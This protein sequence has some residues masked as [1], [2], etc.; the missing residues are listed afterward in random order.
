MSIYRTNVPR[1]AE[2]RDYDA[3]YD[4][5]DNATMFYWKNATEEAM[6]SYVAQLKELEYTK[7][8]E[9]DNACIHSATYC[10]DQLV[11]HVYYLKRTAE[12]RVIVQSDAVLPIN[13]YEY[14]RV[15]DVAVTQLGTYNAPAVYVGMGYLIRLEDGTFV[16]IDGGQTPEYDAKLLYDTMLAQK[17]DGIDDIVI[18]AWIV[19]HGHGDHCGVFIKFLDAY[20]DKVTVKMMIGN[21]ASDL[22][23][24]S[25]VDGH[26]RWFDFNSANGKFGGCVHMK[27]HT[28]QQFRLPGVTLTVL[29]THEDFFPAIM[30]ACN[31][32]NIVVDAVVKGEVAKAPVTAGETRFVFLADITQ[33][34]Q[35]LIRMYGE[36]MRCDVMQIAHHGI[37]CPHYELYTLCHPSFAYW[38]CGTTVLEYKDG[39][40]FQRPHIKYLAQTTEEIIHQANGSHT[41]VFERK[42]Y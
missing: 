17:P 41:F 37:G 10:K 7:H 34:N 31:D 16:V 19:T 27:A 18:T 36:H 14:K 1:R 23:Y 26:G 38:P 35:N 25:F 6:R 33:G 2:D 30:R 5:R 15:C 22:V 11:M 24:Q 20:E 39:I 29:Y 32:V 4:C 8:Q 21:D 12:L 42:D 3:I 40:R 13:A 28:G 9:L